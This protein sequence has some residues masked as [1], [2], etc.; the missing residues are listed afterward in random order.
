MPATLVKSS[1]ISG[2][3]VFDGEKLPDA[4]PAV[5]FYGNIGA[6]KND[7]GVAAYCETHVDGALSGHTYGFGSWINLDTGAVGG[8]N[9][10]AAQDNG[11][12]DN[13]VTLTGTKVIYGMRAE[14]ILQSVPTGGHFPFSLNNNNIPVTAVFDVV[15][16]ADMAFASGAAS[17]GV[18]K[19]PL[20]KAGNTGQLYYVNVYTS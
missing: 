12:Y 5:F 14:S 2:G 19:V 7:L 13:G 20:F 4:I 10:L 1:W 3:L 18:G 17:A 16:I 9:I 6:H 15:Q 8:G 11:I